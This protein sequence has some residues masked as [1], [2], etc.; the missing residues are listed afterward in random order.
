MRKVKDLKD[1]NGEKF[2]P[3]SHAKA[4]YLSDGRT[5]EDAIAEALEKGR[6]L[7]KRD[8]YIAAG[9]LY[10]DTDEVIKRTAFWGEEVDHLPKHYYLN[11]LGDITEEQ[12][13]YIY[14]C[15]EAM[16]IIL[17]APKDS[18]RYFQD[19]DAPRT[20][21]PHRNYRY[22]LG[23]TLSSYYVFNKGIEVVQWCQ[24]SGWELLNLPTVSNVE[25][26][27]FCNKLYAV[28]AFKCSTNVYFGSS[29]RIKH[30]RVIATTAV[31]LDVAKSSIV[32]KA[33]ILYF[34]KNM[35]VPSTAAAS[36]TV[37]TIKLHPD[38]YAI[39]STDE[40]ITTALA[41]KNEA[42]SAKNYTLNLVSA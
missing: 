40:D 5:V 15:K 17:T 8:L 13:A 36:A 2:Y 7:A 31:S 34:I 23:R 3:K 22:A 24:N 26:F 4:V 37:K 6:E 29:D 19:Y 39:F 16:P 10:N 28:N 32:D 42:L 1:N 27:Y 33:S 18:S 9:A 21:F 35:T 25:W 30:F 11:G 12:M 20:L 38:V 41:T 14:N